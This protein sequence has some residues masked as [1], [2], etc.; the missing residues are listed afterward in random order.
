MRVLIV[1]AHP[2]PASFSGAL[3]SVAVEALE[4]SGHEAVVSDLYAEGFDAVAGRGDFT[5]AANSAKFH[6]QAEQAHA[7]ETDSF[8]AEIA[9]EQE[10]VMAA[11]LLVL[12]FPLWWGA[13]HAVLKSWFERVMAYG[14]AYVDGCRFDTGFFKGRRALISVTTGGTPKRFSDEDVYGPIERVL[15]PLKRLAL[16]YMGYEVE[17]PFV[18]YAVPRISDEE[19][20]DCLARWRTRVVA[21]AEAAPSVEIRDPRAALARMGAQA[22]TRA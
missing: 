12:Q 5:G 20:A 17:A 18:S 13:P 6:Y 7:A 1:H 10:R 9:R 2:E 8:V 22:W 4:A 11:D 15:Y 14:F 3:T 19:R 16:E 21:A